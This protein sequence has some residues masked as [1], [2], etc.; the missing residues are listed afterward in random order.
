MG[1]RIIGYALIVGIDALQNEDEHAGM[2]QGLVPTL[3]VSQL[4]EGLPGFRVRLISLVLG[5]K[6]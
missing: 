3:V 1:R 5:G 4:V 6:G 2:G